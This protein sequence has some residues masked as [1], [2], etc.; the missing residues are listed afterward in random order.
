LYR[1]ADLVAVPTKGARACGSL[2][3]GEASATAK[4]VV[5][6][7]VGGVPEYVV[8]GETGLLVP[9]AD[10]AAL[11]TGVSELL[12][13]P[14]RMRSMGCRGLEYVRRTFDADVT[15]AIMDDVL[16]EVVQRWKR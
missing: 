8:Q 3:A 15:N 10:P 14:E 5:G 9:P 12:S 16:Q 11:A 2:A 13:D 1:A 7:N 6:A 4:P